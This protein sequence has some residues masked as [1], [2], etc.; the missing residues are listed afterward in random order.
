MLRWSVVFLAVL[1]LFSGCIVTGRAEEKSNYNPPDW[2]VGD[3]GVV[4]WGYVAYSITE[5]AF[6]QSSTGSG[7]ESL[8]KVTPNE[9]ISSSVEGNV[10]TVCFDS[11][12]IQI[13]KG[14]NGREILVDG[15]SRW[16]GF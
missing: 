5:D 3:W 10:W 7:T 9:K 2:A 8:V 6:I 13:E 14:R 11:L 15:T 16:S 1:I 12:E 4:E